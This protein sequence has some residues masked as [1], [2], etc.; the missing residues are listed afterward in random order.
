MRWVE[1]WLTE[2]TQEVVSD[3]TESSWRPVSSGVPQGLILE[4]V[5]FSTFINH[6]D[7]GIER[8]VS[9]SADDT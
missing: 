1:N 3:G 7:E 5:L 2:R 9:K 4:P 8:T 6:L